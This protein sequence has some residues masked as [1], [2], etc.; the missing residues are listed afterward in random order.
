M[1]FSMIFQSKILSTTTNFTKKIKHLNHT[2]TLNLRIVRVQKPVHQYLSLELTFF[3]NNV[4]GI[5]VNCLNLSGYNLV[6]RFFWRFN[7][8]YNL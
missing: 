6:P 5:S 2:I 4:F 3:D 7:L 1:V 8:F